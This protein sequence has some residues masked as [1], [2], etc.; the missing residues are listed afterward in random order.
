MIKI[1]WSN[2]PEG[3][4]HYLPENRNKNWCACWYKQDRYGRWLV[5][6]AGNFTAGLSD[7]WCIDDEEVD[8]FVPCLIAKNAT[9]SGEGL[10]PAG[11]VCETLYDGNEWGKCIIIAHAVLPGDEEVAVFQC[12]FKISHSSAVYFRPIRTPEQ[13][14]AEERE[15]AINGM[16][17]TAELLDKG[18][19][20]KVCESLYEAGYRKIHEL[21][22]RGGK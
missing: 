9:W 4:T 17:A 8:Q 6:N 7:S 1:D 3:A 11:T 22:G 14:A 10:P 21:A 15:R 13:I 19:C 2:A 18:W 20:R 12:G 5:L 16:V